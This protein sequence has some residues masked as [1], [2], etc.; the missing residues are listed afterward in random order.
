MSPPDEI[1]HMDLPTLEAFI[2]ALEA[3][4][5]QQAAA[6]HTTRPVALPA[7][8]TTPAPP[9]LRQERAAL[10]RIAMLCKDALA[11]P[12]LPPAWRPSFLQIA[13]V[14]R[15]GIQREDGSRGT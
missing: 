15:E 10:W 9:V 14:C 1:P 8:P 12:S 2:T 7:A 6:V 11:S 5:A 3:K 4:F 13:R